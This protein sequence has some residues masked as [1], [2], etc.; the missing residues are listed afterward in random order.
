MGRTHNDD[1]RTASENPK[2]DVPEKGSGPVPVGFFRDNANGT[3]PRPRHF[4][5]APL[6]EKLEA[7]VGIAQL[8]PSDERFVA[9]IGEISTILRHSPTVSI[10][11][12]SGNF[13]G[14]GRRSVGANRKSLAT[15]C[16][17]KNPTQIYT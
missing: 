8:K 16:A 15:S 14:I 1:V 3:F 13:R 17:K 5:R 2:R 10:P 11:R 9:N 6:G 4:P 7:R 12:F